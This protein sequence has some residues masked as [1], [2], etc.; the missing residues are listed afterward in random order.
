MTPPM[1]HFEKLAAAAR[2][3]DDADWGS[4]RQIAA[5]NRFFRALFYHYPALDT[6]SFERWCLKATTEE[7]LDEA[8]V[9]LRDVKPAEAPPPR[10]GKTPKRKR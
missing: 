5:E 3:I 8:M 6:W 4:E 1:K 9:R 7:M 2:P 10:A